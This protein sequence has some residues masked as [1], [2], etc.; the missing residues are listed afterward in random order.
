M[1]GGF[2]SGDKPDDLNEFTDS[3]L[4]TLLKEIVNARIRT[5]ALIE[6]LEEKG[7]I[8]PGEYDNKAQLVWE[9]DYDQLVA[10]IMG[11]ISSN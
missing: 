4:A 5:R 8:T 3:M 7:L 6:L 9:K 10:D 1:L 2:G 11:Q